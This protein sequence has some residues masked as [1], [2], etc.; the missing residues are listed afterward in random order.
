MKLTQISLR[1]LEPK[2]F[3]TARAGTTELPNQQLL[4]P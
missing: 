1:N 2:F 3:N 4:T